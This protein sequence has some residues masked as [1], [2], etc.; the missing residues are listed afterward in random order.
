MTWTNKDLIS[1][2]ETNPDFRAFLDTLATKRDLGTLRDDFIDHDNNQTRHITTEERKRWNQM[3]DDAKSYIDLMLDDIRQKMQ[4]ENSVVDANLAK[5]VQNTIVHVTAA[6]R[7]KWNGLLPS[8]KSYADDKMSSAV[9]AAN[10]YTDEA[11]ARFQEKI[12]A[13]EVVV[14]R[15][16]GVRI[17]VA[18]NPPTKNLVEGGEIWLST[19]DGKIRYFYSNAWKIAYCYGL[20][21]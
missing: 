1:L 4:Q 6:E 18:A 3:Y 19:N 12:D 5:H 21:S 16:N 15:V 9:T 13:N 17:T 7:S 10:K 14:S 2:Y 11:L 20:Y 8:A